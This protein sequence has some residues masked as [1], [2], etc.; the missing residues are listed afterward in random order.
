MLCKQLHPHVALWLK[1][2]GHIQARYQV[3]QKSRIAVHQGVWRELLT[4]IS[5]NSL[6]AHD[7][8]EKKWYFP[9]AVGEATHNE[10][11]VRQILVHLWLFSGIGWLKEEISGGASDMVKAKTRG[12]GQHPR[13]TGGLVSN[14]HLRVN[15][16]KVTHHI[17]R[18]AKNRLD[19]HGDHYLSGLKAK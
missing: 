17:P 13:A 19:G 6:K 12:S 18:L 10:W 7:D 11:A 3:L 15:R 8:C 9:S 2:L 5:G 1:S 16:T 14:L 4:A